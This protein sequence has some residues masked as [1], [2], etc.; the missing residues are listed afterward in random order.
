MLKST[1]EGEVFF[2]QKRVGLHGKLFDLLK[3]ATMLKDS[4]NIGTGSVTL[5]ND[6]RV[7]PMGKFLRKTKINELPQLLNI[8]LG[9]MSIVGPRPQT[10]RCFASFPLECQKKIIEVRPGLSG[11]GSIVFRNEEDLLSENAES[12]NFYDQVIAPYKGE[13]ESWHID[14]S[15]VLVYIKVIILTVWIVLLPNKNL[16]W[17]FFPDLPTPPDEL[18][19]FLH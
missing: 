19:K 9:D 10:Q 11:F 6:P 4:P 8:F 2:V 1:G 13:V 5:K 14:H 16:I 3:F 17:S 12:V 15:T 18:K 7:L